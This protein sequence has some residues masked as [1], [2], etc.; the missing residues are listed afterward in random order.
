MT[1]QGLLERP[2][3]EGQVKRLHASG[4]SDGEIGR[5]LN[6]SRERIRQI[7]SDKDNHKRRPVEKKAFLRTSEV[8][9][10]IGAD[11][12]TIRRWADAGIL[13]VIFRLGSRRD[14]HFLREDVEKFRVALKG[15]NSSPILW[16]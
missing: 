7:R 9:K 10:L 13:P 8:A 15:L 11:A 16:R 5:R 1:V 6:Y 4:L 14:R 3:I 2:N 12:K